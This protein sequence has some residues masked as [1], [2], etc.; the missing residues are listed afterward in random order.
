MWDFSVGSFLQ[1]FQF[2]TLA[3]SWLALVWK[4]PHG[5]KALFFFSRLFFFHCCAQFGRSSSDKLVYAEDARNSRKCLIIYEEF[6]TADRD[7][8]TSIFAPQDN[9]ALCFARTREEKHCKTLSRLEW[10]SL[11]NVIFYCSVT[12][13]CWSREK[14]TQFSSL[15]L[16]LSHFV[17]CCVRLF[18]I[19]SGCRRARESE[20]ACCWS[21]VNIFPTVDA[22]EFSSDF[23]LFHSQEIRGEI[24]SITATWSSKFTLFFLETRVSDSK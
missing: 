18:R 6:F 5:T 21:R 3:L 20:R 15:S 9:K 22:R 2:I 8:V 16:P 23:H 1:I 14:L 19:F 7:E 13:S 10:R 4:S 11:W 17:V 12:A 24:Q